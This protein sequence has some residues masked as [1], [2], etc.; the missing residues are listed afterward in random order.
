M[1]YALLVVS[2]MTFAQIGWMQSTE[3]TTTETGETTLAATEQKKKIKNQEIT[4]ED[5]VRLTFEG[6]SAGDL[7]MAKKYWFPQMAFRY[8]KDGEN[9]LTLAIQLDNAEIVTWLEDHSIINLKNKAGETPLTLAIKKGNPKII[10]I[11]AQRAKGS[12]RNELGETPIVLA[13]QHYDRL[14]FIQTLIQRGADL[15]MRSVG[16]TP[17]SKAV[18]MNKLPIVAMLLKNGADPNVPNLDGTLPM[19]IAVETNREAMV[20]MLLSHSTQPEKDANWKSNLG[21]PILVNAAKRGQ[22]VVVRTLMSYGAYP[23]GTD[24]MDNTA[25][26]IAAQQGN[27]T[28]MQI[29]IENGADVNHVN[30]LGITPVLAAAESGQ[31]EAANYLANQGA[32]LET[33]SYAGLAPTDFYS[34]SGN[35]NTT[36]TDKP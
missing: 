35:T 18:E 9:A 4:E 34:F 24:Y 32:N 13:M 25:L 7:T 31:Y 15:N 6:I 8:N 27:A 11:V 2:L 12:L 30:I 29:L 28:M 19:T 21:E 33:R 5:Q 26:L 10:A 14:D 22:T 1:K 23:N 36:L 20:G 17:L 3:I 16:I